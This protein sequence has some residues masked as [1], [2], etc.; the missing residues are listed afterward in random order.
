MATG[1]VWHERYMWHDTG[2]AA[3][4]F[5][6]GGALEPGE[7]SENPAT[8]RRFRNL[9]EV[10]GLLEHLVPVAPHAA[11]DDELCRFHTREYVERIRELSAGGGGEAGDLTPFGPGGFEI[12]ALSAGGCLAAVDAVVG[13][14]VANAYALVR[15]P[16]HH[17]L[18]DAGLGFCIFGNVALAVLHAREAHGIER[19]A[20]VDWDVH[21]GNGTEAAFW[22]DPDVLTISL[23]QDGCF[24]P[25]SGA[26]DA[27]GESD[28]NIPLPPGS[29]AGA[30]E[31]AF[32]QV[33]VPALEAFRPGL[34]FLACGFD[35][36]AF[37]PLG[38]ML[39][40]SDAYRSLTRTLLDVCGGRLVACHEGGYSA[41]HVPFCGLAVLEELAGVRTG[42]EDPFLPACE[43]MAGQELQPHQRAAIAAAAER[44]ALA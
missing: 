38:R 32:E 43:A 18:A 8:K 44:L 39:L 33:V 6:A 24:P 10:S 29:G 17:A 5:P 26:V 37:D 7:H 12:A 28:V 31:A 42:V 14:D 21:H 20:V 16:G 23:H 2:S 1:F 40:S 3:G 36:G 4:P 19:A 30:Y 22:T 41:S 9:V 35:A 34:V 11:T 27:V 15:P 13:G 25:G